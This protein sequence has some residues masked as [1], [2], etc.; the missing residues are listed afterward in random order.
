VRHQSYAQSS[1]AEVTDISSRI[2]CPAPKTDGWIPGLRECRCCD[3]GA[4]LLSPSSIVAE[5]LRWHEVVGR[6]VESLPL[7][8]EVGSGHVRAVS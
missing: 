4:E 8:G 7:E 6:E 2:G 5:L 3:M 1:V